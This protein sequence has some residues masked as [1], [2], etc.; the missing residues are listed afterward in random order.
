[1]AD[2]FDRLV[3]L[4]IQVH[5]TSI[6]QLTPMHVGIMGTMAQMTL[7][8]LREKIRRGQLGRARAGCIPGGL[9]YGYEVAAPA[10]GAQEAGER[11]IKPAEATTVV[12]IFEDLVKGRSARQIAHAPNAEGV[13]GPGGRLCPTFAVA[14]IDG[15]ELHRELAH[16]DE[17]VGGGFQHGD[18]GRL[19][20][21]QHASRLDAEGCSGDGRDQMPGRRIDRVG[22][23][24]LKRRS[25]GIEAA[26]IPADHLD[27]RMSS[28]PS[29]RGVR[30][31][32]GQQVHDLAALQ[33]HD[34][35]AV[36]AALAPTPVVDP[37][38]PQQPWSRLRR[39]L[40][41]SQDGVATCGQAQP[42][43][44]PM[45]RSAADGMAEKPRQLGRATGAPGG[46]AGSLQ[47]PAAESLSAAKRILA[48]PALDG[49]PDH[50]R[51][52]WAIL[53]IAAVAP[54]P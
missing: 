16:R 29:S 27:V 17:V 7:A 4:R 3:F 24:D 15:S 41:R 19:A 9:A 46:E 48:S 32:V 23:R 10:P 44:Q 18:L 45:R 14:W 20:S 38:D 34:Q 47:S 21:A 37:D 26:A 30:L 33:V 53:K 22:G 11:R 40:E 42:R 35:R 8:D 31:A 36:G 2:L 5:A 12:R 50:D 13:P 43:R 52:P 49:D 1:M 6:G 54:V 28:E 39:A 25:Q 51:P